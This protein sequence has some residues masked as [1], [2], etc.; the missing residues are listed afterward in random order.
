M[1]DIPEGYVVHM[2]PRRLRIKVPEKRR[3]SSFFS[4]ARQRLSQRPSVR[5]IEVNPATGSILI[6][7]SDPRAFLGALGSDGPFTIVEQQREAEGDLP[8][9]EQAREQIASWDKQIQEWTGSRHDTRSYIFFA[10][11]LAAAYQIIRGDIFGPAASLLW[12][13]VVV[14]RSWGPLK[15]QSDANSD[16]AETRDVS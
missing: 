9:I 10:L 2:T 6:H 8:L 11:M 13:A 16:E 14:L 4:A 12:Y 1:H 3:D 15:A 5:G 7:S